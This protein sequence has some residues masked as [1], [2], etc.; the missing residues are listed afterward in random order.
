MQQELLNHNI[1]IKKLQDDGYEIEITGDHII[2]SNI[3]YLNEEKKIKYG[4]LISTLNRTGNKILKPETHVAYFNG[5]EPCDIDSNKLTSVINSSTNENHGGVACN[6]MLSNK[7]VDGYNDYY[8]KLTRYIEIISGPANFIDKNVTAKTFRKIRIYQNDNLVYSDT[9]SSRSGI[10]E[11]NLK[12]RTQ[13][14]GI[15]GLGGTGSYILDLISKTNV[16]EIHLFDGDNFFQHNAF[17]S[18]GAPTISKL[19]KG[20]KKVAYFKGIYKNIHNKIITHPYFLNKKNVMKMLSGLDFVFICIDNG[21][22]RRIIVDMLNKENIKF[23]DSGISVIKEG[24]MLLG[25]V[26]NTFISKFDD[27][28]LMNLLSFDNTNND[29]YNSNIQIAEINSLAAVHA[30]IK[31]KK[32][33]LLY[34]DNNEK[35]NFVYD[36]NDGEIKYED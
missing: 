8:D 21:E 15:I 17:R 3:P 10:D 4:K 6:Y 16:E 5:E 14:I 30:V 12:L 11:I 26:R 7:P 18:P 22:A 1:D 2:V 29:L 34:I 20:Q 19:S 23:I 9:N 13:K 32:D 25:S 28:K 36:T 27:E 31:W 24:N 35:S 33:S